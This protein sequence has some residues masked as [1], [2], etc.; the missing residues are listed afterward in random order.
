MGRLIQLDDED[1]VVPIRKNFMEGIQ[2]QGDLRFTTSFHLATI[3]P[4]Y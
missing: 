2:G 1:H 3:E 4:G